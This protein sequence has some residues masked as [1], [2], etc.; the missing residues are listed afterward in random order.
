MADSVYE[1]S[2]NTAPGRGEEDEC[3]S[4]F[5]QGPRRRCTYI[6]GQQGSAPMITKVADGLRQG[7]QQETHTE[8]QDSISEK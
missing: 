4:V 3:S 6:T 7:R 2:M 8:T 5:G 1:D